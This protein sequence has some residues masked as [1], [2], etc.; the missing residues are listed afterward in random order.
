M[1]NKLLDMN[2]AEM[3]NALVALATPL[4]NFMDDAEFSEAFKECTKNGVQTRSTDILQ[5]YTTL[6]PFL[7][8]EKHLRDTLQILSIIEGTT[9][10]KML[11]M[12]GTD[13]IADAFDAWGKQIKPFF[14]RLGLTA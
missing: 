5:I 12:N 3:A 6:V 8:G 4:R 13:L 2:G 9:V 14:M 11:K 7:F 10:S 1:A